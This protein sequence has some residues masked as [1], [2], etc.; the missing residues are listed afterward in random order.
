M[1]RLAIGISLFF[2]G[3]VVYFAGIGIEL[4]LLL[5]FAGILSLIGLM[6]TLWAIVTHKSFVT[7]QNGQVVPAQE[8]TALMIV[9]IVCGIIVLV[10]SLYCCMGTLVG[11]LLSLYF[12]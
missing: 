4:L 7:L 5:P 1:K 10:I 6:I 2:I 12:Y 8:D 11:T 3:L 9:R